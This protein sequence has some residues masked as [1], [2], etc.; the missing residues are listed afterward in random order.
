MHTKENEGIPDTSPPLTR[1]QMFMFSLFWGSLI[2][3]GFASLLL[4]LK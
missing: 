3:I 1:N 4:Q 2:C